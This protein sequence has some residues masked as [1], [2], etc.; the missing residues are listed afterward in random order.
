MIERYSRPEMASVWSEQGKLDRWLRVEIAVVDAWADAG[1][2]PRE[3]AEKIRR[4]SFNLGDIARY[5][6]ETHHDVTAFLK[7]V[8]ATKGAG[9]T[10]A[11]PRRTSGTPPPPSSCA[12]LR[13]SSSETWKRCAK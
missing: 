7:S 13:R 9:C 12:T 3:D 2:V 8:A 11:L 6:E 4:A 5:Q 10:L 1:R